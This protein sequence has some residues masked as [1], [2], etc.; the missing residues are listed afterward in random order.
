MIDNQIETFTATEARESGLLE[1]I[2]H[3]TAKVEGTY[4][5]TAEGLKFNQRAFVFK[6]KFGTL[7]VGRFADER[8]LME[9]GDGY[10]H[11]RDATKHE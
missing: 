3:G 10:P 5:L 1:A 4:E 11:E 7:R 9:V 2:R 6:D 8:A